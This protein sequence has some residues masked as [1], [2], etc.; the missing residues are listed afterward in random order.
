MTI[1]RGRWVGVEQLYKY[2][3]D[4]AP[5]ALAASGVPKVRRQATARAVAEVRM[6]LFTLK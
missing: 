3:A 4:V 6:N 1:S 5:W 2:V